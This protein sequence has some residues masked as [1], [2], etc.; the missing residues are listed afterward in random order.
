MK[1]KRRTLNY[2]LCP[3]LNP[4]KPYPASETTPPYV[5]ERPQTGQIAGLPPEKKQN[6]QKIYKKTN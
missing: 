3:K 1:E 4:T 2:N 6:I 5:Q